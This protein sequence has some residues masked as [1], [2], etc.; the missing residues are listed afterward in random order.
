[1]MSFYGTREPILL[2]LFAMMKSIVKSFK[3]LVV[4]VVA[5]RLSNE[6]AYD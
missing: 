3:V 4:E 6:T 2:L 1:M 5:A